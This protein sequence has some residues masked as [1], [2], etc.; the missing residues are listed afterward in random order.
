MP[1]SDAQ[2]RGA[3]TTGMRMSDGARDGRRFRSGWASCLQT[4]ERERKE[5]LRALRQQ[6]E[7]LRAFRRGKTVRVP[8]RIRNRAGALINS[9]G[10]V[11]MLI[12]LSTLGLR[13][14]SVFTALGRRSGRSRGEN[15]SNNGRLHCDEGRHFCGNCAAEQDDT[16]R[17]ETDQ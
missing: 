7:D 12:L 3:R 8:T 6:V 2:A 13:A 11:P 14:L 15:G 4:G 9:A 16:G 10:A 1:W 17:A 5:W